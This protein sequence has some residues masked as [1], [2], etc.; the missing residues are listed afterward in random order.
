MTRFSRFLMLVMVLLLFAPAVQAVPGNLVLSVPDWDITGIAGYPNWCAPTAGGN[1]M[2]YWE[3]VNGRT[4]LTDRQAEPNGPG[5]ANNPGTYKQGLYRDGQIEMG[6]HMGTQGWANPNLQF[7][8]NTSF[9]TNTAAIAPGLKA[10]AKDA[11]VDP[12]AAGIQKVAYDITTGIDSKPATAV[13]WQTYTG[14]IDASRPALCSFD[15]WVNTGS[16]LNP[17]TWTLDTFPNQ[18]LERYAWDL[19]TDPHCVVG[20]G[21]VDQT[22]GF[23]GDGIDEWFIC[24]DGWST[25]GQY[26]AV[27]VDTMWQQNVYV[28]SVTEAPTG[29]IP[30]PGTAYL[31]L[32]GVVVILRRRWR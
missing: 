24:Q 9:G 19:N 16:L 6:Y 30:E 5:H 20:V 18:T 13:M 14:E 25:T 15:K 4:G 26:V 31:V 27:P 1:L 8:P 22:A 10:Y 3:D 28:F 29:V 12:G 2:G 11:Y 23:Q 21:Y 32:T 17:P 7:P